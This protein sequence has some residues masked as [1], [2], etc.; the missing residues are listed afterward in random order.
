MG[1]ELQTNDQSQPRRPLQRL[2]K[3]VARSS[4]GL[5]AG[6]FT[7]ISVHATNLNEL[8]DDLTDMSLEALMNIEVSSVSKKPQNN[9]KLPPLFSSLPMMICDAGA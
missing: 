8:P 2:T 5:V 4:L 6:L 9:Q 1:T 3:Y 7:A